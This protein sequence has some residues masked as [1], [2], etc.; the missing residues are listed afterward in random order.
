VNLCYQFFSEI[1]FTHWLN[2]DCCSFIVTMRICMGA[3]TAEKLRGTKVWV[4]TPGRLRQ[5][6]PPPA[7]RVHGYYPRTI[8]ENSDAK[9][10][11]L[12]TTCCEIS[13]FLKTTAKK[14]GGP[15]HSW[16]PQHKSWGTSLRG[17][18]GCCA[19][20][21]ICASYIERVGGR[22]CFLLCNVSLQFS[23]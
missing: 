15:I 2:A 8:F 14:L 23:D 4:P 5:A 1:N 20:V 22:F 11:I 19:Y 6:S 21:Y 12:V 16:S 13:C 17:P 18:C 10:C 7:V 3:T 9:P